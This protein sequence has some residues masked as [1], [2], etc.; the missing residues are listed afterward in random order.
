MHFNNVLYNVL[1]NG[2]LEFLLEYLYPS[3]K[4]TLKR[5]NK[6]TNQ[7]ITWGLVDKNFHQ[8]VIDTMS[9][10]MGQTM[11]QE[12]IEKMQLH[13]H[14][15]SGSFLLQCLTGNFWETSD[16]DFYFYAKSNNS[17][18]YLEKNSRK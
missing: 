12:I 11:G 4:V 16:V 8:I 1:Y 7:K 9:R 14:V 6:L 5:I 18:D 13:N 10:K 17:S 2:L 15:L 3:D